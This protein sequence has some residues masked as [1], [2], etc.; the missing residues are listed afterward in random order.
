MQP[1]AVAFAIEDCGDV[2]ELAD[3]LLGLEDAA[4]GRFDAVEYVLQVIAGVEPDRYPGVGAGPDA[5]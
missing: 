3:G 2:A 5:P 4:A 1:D